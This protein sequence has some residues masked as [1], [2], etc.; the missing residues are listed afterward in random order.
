[1]GPC[2]DGGFI[3]RSGEPA[4]VADGYLAEDVTGL[5]VRDEREGGEEEKE[6]KGGAHGRGETDGE[7]I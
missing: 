1:M 4:L 6:A 3:A 5:S 7:E 2:V